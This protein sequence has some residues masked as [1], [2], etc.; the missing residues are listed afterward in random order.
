MNAMFHTDRLMT[1]SP[2]DDRS[3]PDLLDD[4]NRAALNQALEDSD[5]D[6]TAGRLVDADIVLRQLRSR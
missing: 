6:I 2:F 1:S 5:K 4:D 3:V